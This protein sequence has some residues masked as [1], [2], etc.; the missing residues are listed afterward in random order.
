MYI[1]TE[2]SFL[3]RVD[4]LMSRVRLLKEDSFLFPSN[5]PNRHHSSHI[6]S[7]KMMEREE[8]LKGQTQRLLT[9]SD[10]EAM[11]KK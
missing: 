1:S 5:E 3:R 9:K 8:S 6:C 11:L 7:W 2:D 4:Y 10:Q